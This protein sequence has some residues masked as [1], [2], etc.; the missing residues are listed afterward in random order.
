VKALSTWKTKFEFKTK[1]YS[2]TKSLEIVHTDLCGPTRTK[3]LNGEQYFK[4]LIDE[5]T[6]MT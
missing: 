4:P 3:G 1:E 2:T 6:R 5:Y